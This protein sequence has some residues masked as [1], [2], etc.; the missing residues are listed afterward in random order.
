MDEASSAIGKATEMI[1]SSGGLLQEILSFSENASM[2]INGIATAA[3]EQSATFEEINRNVDSINQIA[4]ST[5]DS[6]GV[7]VT[8]LHDLSEQAAMLQQLVEELRNG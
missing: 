8:A 5:A 1:E 4:T 6:M 3:E 7:T 2:Q